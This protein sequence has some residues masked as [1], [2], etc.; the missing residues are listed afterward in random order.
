MP[1]YSHI[2]TLIYIFL[3]DKFFEKGISEQKAQDLFQQL[4]KMQGHLGNNLKP[5]LVWE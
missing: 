5:D 2:F 1:F 4:L 3:P